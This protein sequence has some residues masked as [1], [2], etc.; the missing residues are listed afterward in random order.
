M[1]ELWVLVWVL[2]QL[3]WDVLHIG[4]YERRKFQVLVDMAVIR[5]QL[6]HAWLMVRHR[7]QHAGCLYEEVHKYLL[8][9]FKIQQHIIDAA[10][11]PCL[12]H[13]LIFGDN[14]ACI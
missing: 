10:A 8:V 7:I 4:E 2:H 3:I 5:T 12:T 6:T 11:N 14:L 13:P 9:A 1:M